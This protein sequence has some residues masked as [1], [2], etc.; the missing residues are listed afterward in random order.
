VTRVHVAGGWHIDVTVRPGVARLLPG[1]EVARV[2]AA[3]L[4]AAGAPEPAGL[5]VVLA[6]DAEL[7]ELNETHLGHERPTDVLS[8]P[9]LQPE[10]FPAHAGR[11]R[12]G[13]PRAG[14]SGS[15]SGGRTA[16]AAPAAAPTTPFVLPPGTRPHLGDIVLSVERAIAQAREGRGGQTGDVRWS[17][18]EEL[19]LL[20]THGA[21]H[22]C[23]WD[24][25]EP[26]EEAA[27]RALEQRL[28]GDSPA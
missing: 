9:L 2:V 3:A 27:M 11:P 25:A 4:S 13:R 5:S 20:L 16:G 22:V 23:G 17:A 21:L 10:A 19:R 28:L 1:A 15:S 12:A 7:A 24:H 8:F 18:A 6:D 14:R 26:V